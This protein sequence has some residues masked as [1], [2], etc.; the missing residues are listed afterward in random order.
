MAFN[1]VMLAAGVIALLIGSY[2]DLKTR[3]VPDWVNYGLIAFG[4]GSRLIY[5]LAAFDWSYIIEGVLGLLLF[6]VLAYMMFYAGQWGGGDSKMMMGMGALIGLRF[7]WFDF[8]LSF[9]VNILLVGAIYGLLWSIF[10]AARNWH[11]FRKEVKSIIR[12]PRM[13]MIRKIFILSAAVMIILA[14]FV[15]D[16]YA[17]LILFVFVAFYLATFYLWVF[18]RAIERTCMLKLVEPER[19]TEGD[20]IA[21]DV[22]V[23]GKKICGPKDLGIEMRQIRQLIKLKKQ[24]KIKKILI[25][26]GI[27]FVPSFL[28]AFIVTFLFG[29]LFLL[30]V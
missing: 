27:P 7:S 2:S 10:L 23:E 26:E 8:S 25:K 30:L 14:F 24:R 29:N 11:K 21:K 9:L 5:S 17:K 6:L 18:I 19:L 1:M 4:L 16:F 12:K 3:E 22:V 28:L 13:I 15:R 20:W